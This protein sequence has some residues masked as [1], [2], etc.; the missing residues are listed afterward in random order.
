MENRWFLGWVLSS[1]DGLKAGRVQVLASLKEN[2]SRDY[3]VDRRI[4]EDVGIDLGKTDKVF[5]PQRPA[6]DILPSTLVRFQC[7][8]TNDY[9]S[10]DF[11]ERDW[12]KIRQ[13]NNKWQCERFGNRV[14]EVDNF[15]FLNCDSPVL[16]GVNEN[17]QVYLY[18][19][20]NKRYLGLWI[21]GK[22][23]GEDRGKSIRPYPTQK[24]LFAFEKLKLPPGCEYVFPVNFERSPIPRKYLLFRPKDSLG[25]RYD[26]YTQKQY[27]DWCIEKLKGLAPEIF[28]QIAKLWPKWKEVLTD[29]LI[30]LTSDQIIHNQSRWER[31]IRDFSYLQLESDS[32]RQLMT[33]EHFQKR[34]KEY[35]VLEQQQASIIPS[36]ANEDFVSRLKI[37][38]IELQKQL[39]TEKKS[40]ADEISELNT[41]L[42]QYAEEILQLKKELKSVQEAS[43]THSESAF[44]YKNNNPN[45]EVFE[46]TD[47]TVQNDFVEKRLWPILSQKYPNG[48]DKTLAK[49]LHA[50]VLGSKAILVPNP[51]W[52]KSY[53]EAIGPSAVF[54][55]IHVEPIWIRFQDLWEGGLKSVW[56]NAHQRNDK[57]YFVLLRDF[58]RALP[59]YYARPLLDLIAGYSDFLEPADST[60]WPN[61]LRLFVC[62]SKE[63]ESLPLTV[64][65]LHHFSAIGREVGRPAIKAE[66]LEEGYV[67][68]KTWFNW[69]EEIS[70]HLGTVLNQWNDLVEYE[71]ITKTIQLDCKQITQVMI[72]LRDRER[73]AIEY[74]KEIRFGIPKSY[75]PKSQEEM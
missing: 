14:V 42:G 52:A 43:S 61:N 44:R 22:S 66:I 35:I 36:Q 32:I 7:E 58:N 75:L 74:A 67:R 71:P 24:D 19:T 54:Q 27:A 51:V 39:D 30:E 17:E 25:T 16:T 21:V 49:F 4:G 60:A 38:I 23:I 56:Q 11:P 26:W 68:A 45:S 57:L 10:D 53:A 73:D 47:L 65:V 1:P 70:K 41:K 8:Q 63:N 15:D 48:I 6:S 20:S 34:I 5:W 59:Q 18:D 2:S 72:T 50:A 69:L 29:K 31:L 64:E 28:S 46:G 33:N 62:P 55:T 13:I 3:V 9:G 37:Q 12:W 40:K